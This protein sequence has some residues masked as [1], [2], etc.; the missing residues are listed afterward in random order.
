M[1]TKDT[2]ICIRVTDYS[3]TSQI[4]TLFT[5][6]TGKINAI[7]K[8]SKRPKSA[9]DGPLE[10]FSY[11]EIVFSDSSR[12]KLATL[13]E[14][15]Q[16]PC[17][18]DLANNLFA[19]NCCLFGA[20]LV[21]SLTHDYDP[22]PELFDSFLQFL[23]RTRDTGHESRV[24]ISLLILFQLT[25]LRE[26][27]L[28]PIL[29]ACA[30]CKTSHGT[31]ATSHEFY[32]SSSANGLICKDC[33]ASFPDKVKLTKNT[34]DCLANTKLLA[35]AQEKTLNEIEKVLVKHFTEIL[36]HQPKIAKYILNTRATE[37][38]P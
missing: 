9:F 15:Q 14:F 32:F 12:E 16:Q 36:H 27:G 33:E 10:V 19:L 30:N 35:E 38:R 34:A 22:H 1:L 28:M 5:K 21:N 24:T 6:A 3:E 23:K 20:E 11:G 31:R 29:N 8:G 4:V 13:T 37:P 26:I 17:F 2:A 18:A 25:L 7:A